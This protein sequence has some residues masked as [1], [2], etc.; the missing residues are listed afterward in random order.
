MVA[1]TP[2][3]LVL[4]AGDW[5]K[6]GLPPQLSEMLVGLYPGKVAEQE[7]PKLMV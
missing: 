7:V 5:V 6:V 3:K 4:A 2:D 1:P